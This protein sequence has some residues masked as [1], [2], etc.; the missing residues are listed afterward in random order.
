MSLTIVGCGGGSETVTTS[1]NPAVETNVA[2]N[3]QTQ[4]TSS[5]ATEQNSGVNTTNSVSLSSDTLTPN[6]VVDTTTSTTSTTVDSATTTATADTTTTTTTTADV[7][8]SP[9][10]APVI[11]SLTI[12]W[13]MPVERSDNTPLGPSEVAGYRIY[14]GTDSSN[15][16]L[17]ATIPDNSVTKYTIGSLSSG[18]HYYSVTTYDIYGTESAMTVIGSETII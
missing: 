13:S 7:T 5:V 16:L 3:T 2:D 9:A 18:T 8:Q 15:L 14:Y 12:S 10:P 4:N 11:D 6:P 17:L 1:E